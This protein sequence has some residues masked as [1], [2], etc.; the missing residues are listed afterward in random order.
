MDLLKG[1]LEKESD[2]R[3]SSDKAMAHPAFHSLMSKSPLIIKSAFN[4]DSL[5]KHQNVVGE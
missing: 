3:I 5:I 2:K 4:A 1:M